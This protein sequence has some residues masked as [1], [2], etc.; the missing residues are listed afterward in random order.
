MTKIGI[1]LGSTRPGRNGEAVAHWVHELAAKRDD[2]EFELID[3]LDY[4]LPHLDEM[5]PPSMG[6]YAQPHTQAWARTIDSFDGFIMVTP[7]YNH[8]TSGALKNA[9]DFLY[10]E[11]NNKAVGFVSYGGAGGARAVEHLRLIAGEL[12]M[13]DVRAQVALS[14]FHDFVNFSEF[15][16]TDFQVDALTTVFD[17][18]IAWSEA[19][20][21]LRAK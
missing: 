16:P 8:S 5:L 4:K 14:L 11:W 12:Q 1:I 13:A 20:A 18:V 2:A 17:Q 6:Q 9:I 19:L 10:A 7:E 21:P 3:L 15:K